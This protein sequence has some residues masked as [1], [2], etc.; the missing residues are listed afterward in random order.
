MICRES[1]SAGSGEFSISVNPPGA[2]RQGPSVIGDSVASRS[3]GEG[4]G[5]SRLWQLQAEE[6]KVALW[7]F[8]CT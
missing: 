7:Q 1:I 6:Q 3:Y 5:M 2:D 8:S 4:V